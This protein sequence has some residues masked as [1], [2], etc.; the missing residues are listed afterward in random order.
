MILKD[1]C[2]CVSV[3]QV[4]KQIRRIYNSITS[5]VV[6]IITAVIVL[7]NTFNIRLD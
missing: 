6:I 3:T 1:Q 2:D 4:E 5:T 7:N